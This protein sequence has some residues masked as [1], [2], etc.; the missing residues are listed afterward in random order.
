MTIRMNSLF[1]GVALLCAATATAQT[2]SYYSGTQTNGMFGSNT[3]GGT[4]SGST[5]RST[6]GS[7]G[8][9]SGTSAGTTAGQPNVAMGAQNVAATASANTRQQTVGA[10]VGADS[11]DNQNPLSRQAA[12]GANSAAGRGGPGGMNGL[13]QLQSLF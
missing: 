2:S 12:T 3:L 1:L 8:T 9:S 5:G 6:T 7:G 13:S 11:A 10:F 4:S